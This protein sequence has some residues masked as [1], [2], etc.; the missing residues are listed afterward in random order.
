[1]LLSMAR[2][3]PQ[4][5]QSL[6]NKEWNRNAFKG[7]ELYHKTLGVIGAGRIG[8]GV[9]KRAQSFGMKILAFDPYLTDEK[10]KSLS[11]TK[12]TVDEIAQH[13]DFITL[14]TPLTPKTKGLINADFLPKAKP[15]LQ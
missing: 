3:I 12:A 8:L 4:A 13:S 11:I 6:T 15:S 1:M 5:H 7:T 14:H 10:A 9:A 2:N